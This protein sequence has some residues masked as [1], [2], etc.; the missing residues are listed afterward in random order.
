MLVSLLVLW[1]EITFREAENS[2]QSSDHL[3][4]KQEYRST[5]N[6]YA[7]MWVIGRTCLSIRIHIE[8]K[9]FCHWLWII[10]QSRPY[11]SLLILDQWPMYLVIICDHREI[12][13]D[14]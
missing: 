9:R 7:V 2:N 14:F 11:E 3:Q 10:L 5:S 13:E 12:L 8:K 6:E 1:S 4:A